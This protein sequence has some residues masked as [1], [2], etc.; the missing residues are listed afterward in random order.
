M[1]EIIAGV[2]EAGVGPIAGPVVAAAVILNP[3]QI[4]YKLRDSKILTETQ[5]E[6]LYTRIYQNALA[7]SIGIATVEE[8]DTLNIFY[9]TML[10]MERAIINLSV[11]PTL[12]LIDGKNSPKIS[13][14]TKTIVKGDQT[15]KPIS[16]ASIIAKVTRDRLMKNLHLEHPKYN[17][18][19]H[20]G[21]STKEHQKLLHQF[22][23]C[24]FHRRSFSI[25]K[26]FL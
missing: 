24:P 11:V 4:I 19:K 18:A 17:F 25:V 6:V 26:K 14:P 10:A 13:L 12:I 2:D 1:N 5:R 23:P 21:Y 15:E 9:A 7:V 20:K 16:A 8:I 22:G 3:A